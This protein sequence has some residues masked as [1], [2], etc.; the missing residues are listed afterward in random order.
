MWSNGLIL[1]IPQMR[2]P[3]RES[4]KKEVIDCN[5]LDCWIVFTGKREGMKK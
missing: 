5:Y 4:R 2:H 1:L 3:H